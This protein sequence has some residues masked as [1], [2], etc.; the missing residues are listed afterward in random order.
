MA[1][2]HKA[3]KSNDFQDGNSAEGCWVDRDGN[4]VEQFVGSSG[5]YLIVTAPDGTV[6][7]DDHPWQMR[8]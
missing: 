4:H 5:V 2:K 8:V 6:L 7:R 3:P 1:H